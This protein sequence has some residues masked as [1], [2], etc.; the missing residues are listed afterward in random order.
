MKSD[1]PKIISATLRYFFRT[2]RPFRALLIAINPFLVERNVALNQ[3]GGTSPVTTSG[4]CSSAPERWNKL[5]VCWSGSSALE[6]VQNASIRQLSFRESESDVT[7]V[8]VGASRPEKWMLGHL[9]ESQSVF[10]KHIAAYGSD[11]P[12]PQHQ[13]LTQRPIATVTTTTYRGVS[14]AIPFLVVT[15]RHSAK[16]SVSARE[17]IP[18]IVVTV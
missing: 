15:Q 10:L 16:R 1:A 3:K 12:A 18:P 4:I 11:S 2:T 8:L 6:A 5:A 14:G 17:S 7:E 9:A 13:V